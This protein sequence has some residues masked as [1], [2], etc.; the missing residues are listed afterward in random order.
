MGQQEATQHVVGDFMNPRLIDRIKDQL[1]VGQ[2]HN[3]QDDCIDAIDN[4][5]PGFWRR[6]TE[7]S[8]WQ[9][10]K[11]VEIIELIG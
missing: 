1:G 9:H 8:R 10:R 2:H 6:F 3:R 11:P 5:K 7:V 4:A